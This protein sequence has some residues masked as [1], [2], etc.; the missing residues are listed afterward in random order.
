MKLEETQEKVRKSRDFL[1][2]VQMNSL[3]PNIQLYTLY[4]F[5]IFLFVFETLVGP[6]SLLFFLKMEKCVQLLRL[7]RWATRII[8]STGWSG[9]IL[10][11]SDMESEKAPSFSRK[12]QE[13]LGKGIRHDVCEPCVKESS[14]YIY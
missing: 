10:C 2:S 12:S 4:S 13:K 11:I 3:V 6:E 1:S 5:L 9:K 8:C 14:I 7:R